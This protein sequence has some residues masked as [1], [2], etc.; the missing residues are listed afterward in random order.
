MPVEKV[1]QRKLNEGKKFKIY[2]INS[3]NEKNFSDKNFI[4]D[5]YKIKGFG[6]LRLTDS[7]DHQW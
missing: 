7:T 1:N 2:S 3:T 5:R 6:R 4:N